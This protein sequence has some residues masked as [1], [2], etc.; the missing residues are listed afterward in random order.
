MRNERIGGT[1][2]LQLVGALADVL[3]AKLDESGML[4]ALAFEY[5]LGP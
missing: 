2:D 5:R 1:Q 3:K 4:D